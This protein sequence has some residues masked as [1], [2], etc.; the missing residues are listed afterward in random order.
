MCVFEWV[1]MC[2]PPVVLCVYAY[3]CVGWV[4]LWWG[5][6]E[7]GGFERREGEVYLLHAF[8]I[9]T[10]VESLADEL[11]ADV[12]MPERLMPEILMIDEL[13]VDDL[14]TMGL[15]VEGL[16][17][18]VLMSESLMPE[19]LVLKDALPAGLTSVLEES[20]VEDAVAAEWLPAAAGWPM[21]W[22]ALADDALVKLPN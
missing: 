21:P 17:T 11:V 9:R 18:N 2:V 6:E 10:V 16:V 5:Q 3:V 7:E 1:S 12:L 15:L 14:V 19:V 8:E 4:Y 22:A 20:M 13:M